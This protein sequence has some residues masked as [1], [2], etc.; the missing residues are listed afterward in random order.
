MTLEVQIMTI[1]NAT[2][3]YAA[4]DAMK[5][6]ANA[7]KN[8]SR[9]MTIEDVEDTMEDIR[10]QMDIADEIGNAIAQPLGADFDEDELNAELDALEQEKLDAELSQLD[11]RAAQLPDLKVPVAQPA[12]R[13]KQQV[14]EEADFKA[15]EEE[16]AFN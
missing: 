9:T 14:E 1:E 12:Q 2:T 13:S 15:L 10:E 16:L 8:I 3:N 11:A 4:L 7:L 6:G 5:T